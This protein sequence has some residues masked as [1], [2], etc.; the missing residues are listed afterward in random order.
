MLI[1][2]PRL[3]NDRR[4]LETYLGANQYNIASDIIKLRNRAKAQGMTK[5]VRLEPTRLY[6]LSI[7]PEVPTDVLPPSISH[8]CTIYLF[9]D[10]TTILRSMSKTKRAAT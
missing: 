2:L 1:A 10:S 6:R 7:D 5:A 4:P 3:D 8:T 9:G